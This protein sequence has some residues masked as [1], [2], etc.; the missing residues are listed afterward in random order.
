MILSRALGNR[1]RRGMAIFV[2]VA[3]SWSA[4]GENSYQGQEGLR[5]KMRKTS[6]KSMVR[7]AH[8][9]QANS[10]MTLTAREKEGRNW[11]FRTAP[12]AFLA[13]WFTLDVAYR[14]SDQWSFGPSAILFNAKG[15][16]SMLA[17]SY[18][19]YAVGWNGSYHFGS[20][21]K[22]SWYI[23]AHGYYESYKLYPHAFSG[24]K[25]VTGFSGYSVIGYQWRWSRVNILSGIGPQI[26]YQNVVE[27]TR[28][29]NDVEKSPVESRDVKLVPTIEFKVGFEI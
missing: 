9:S 26:S 19:G 7:R 24:H 5:T 13:S 12:L 25:E 8:G 29:L 10:A 4:F 27:R 21:R 11:E 1:L 14:L 16:G 17:P 28:P 2:I 22:N 23:S 20:V 15:P 18:N 6:R 3:F